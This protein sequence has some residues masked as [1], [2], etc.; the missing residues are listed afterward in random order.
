MP[1]VSGTEGDLI[2]FAAEGADGA[3]VAAVVAA[4]VA[5]AAAAA[6]DISLA[7]LCPCRCT[8]SP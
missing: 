4:A 5:A 7:R 8:G 3:A 2:F 1:C 6:S